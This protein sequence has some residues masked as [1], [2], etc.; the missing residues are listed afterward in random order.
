MHPDTLLTATSIS[1]TTQ[2]IRRPLLS[3]LLHSLSDVSP[4]LIWGNILH[5]VMQKCL[6]ARRWDDVYL[7]DL[8]DK[9]VQASLNELIK[10]NVGID[11]AKVEIRKRAM[12]LKSFGKRFI[13]EE[14]NVC[15][16]ILIMSIVFLTFLFC[17]QTRF[18]LTREMLKIRS[19]SLLSRNFTTSKK[20]YGPPS[21]DSRERLTHLFKQRFLNLTRSRDCKLL[22]QC[23]SK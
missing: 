3:L 18:F 19:R 13:T 5:D 1:N 11:E 14:P 22:H 9:G 10:I 12:G 21:S 2:C 20:I 23:P 15:N 7:E 16:F 4:A 6:A 17:R 8:I